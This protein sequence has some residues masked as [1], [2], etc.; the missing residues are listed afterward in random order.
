MPTSRKRQRLLSPG[1]D[2][3]SSLIN[4]LLAHGGQSLLTSE[5]D[6]QSAPVNHFA[7][8]APELLEKIFIRSESLSMPKVSRH[9]YK[10]LSSEIVRLRFCTHVFYHGKPGMGTNATSERLGILQTQIFQQ[11]W[12]SLEFAKKVGSRCVSLPGV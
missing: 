11:K 5:G 9:F 1:E 7:S 6:L 10:S 3:Q 8:L 4:M 2:A 12:F